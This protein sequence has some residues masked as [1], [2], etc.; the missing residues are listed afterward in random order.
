M[1]DSVLPIR[2]AVAARA[3]FFLFFLLFL[4]EFALRLDQ[5]LARLVGDGR[6]GTAFCIDV[7]PHLAVNGIELAIGAAGVLEDGRTALGP[8]RRREGALVAAYLGVLAPQLLDDALFLFRQFGGVLAARRLPAFLDR[9]QV[10]GI[11]QGKAATANRLCRGRGLGRR[12]DGRR[13]W[14]RTDEPVDLQNRDW[15]RD[16]LVTFCFSS[17]STADASTDRLLPIR[18]YG[19]SLTM[20]VRIFGN[21]VK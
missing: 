20:I 6:L 2:P 19:G 12:R 7:D 13:D 11:D 17:A 18:E 14:R 5:L 1:A 9:D 4:A 3:G 15:T 10:G 21:S 8:G 16:H